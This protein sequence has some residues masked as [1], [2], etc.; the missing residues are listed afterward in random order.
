MHH[1]WI[2]IEISFVSFLLRLIGPRT[3]LYTPSLAVPGQLVIICTWLGVSKKVIAKYV[4]LYQV[5]APGAKILLIESNV[6]ILVSSVCCS[7]H[8]CP[9][10]LEIEMALVFESLIMR[11][12]LPWKVLR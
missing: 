1:K 10:L 9:G 2:G 4:A 11:I 8:S 6:P 5:I 3:S 12:V 7:F